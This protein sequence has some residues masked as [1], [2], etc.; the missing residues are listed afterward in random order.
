MGSDS[1]V[2]VNQGKG[3]LVS[4]KDGE[5]LAMSMESMK[6]MMEMSGIQDLMTSMGEQTIQ[7]N[8]P[9]QFEKTGRVETIGGIT[10]QV[11]L[12]S[13][14]NDMGQSETVEIVFGD[15]PRLMRLHQAQA[16]LAE[17]SEIMSGPYEASFSEFM[18][19]YAENGPGDAMLRYSD[20]MK[21]ESVEEATLA[22]SRFHVP[23]VKE[24]NLGSLQKIENPKHV[25]RAQ[26]QTE[27]KSETD[28]DDVLKGV[29]SLLNGLSGILGN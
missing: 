9:P 23:R 7:E 26:R 5:W 1:Y 29:D 24:M 18:K 25:E 17:S 14:D 11:Y 12:M 13:M 8:R 2:L 19:T 21:L 22:Q 15:D 27:E 28:L 20:M 4:K 6:K 16:R 3:Y 10:G